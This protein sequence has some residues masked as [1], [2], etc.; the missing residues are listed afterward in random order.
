MYR[1]PAPIVT[2]AASFGD[3]SATAKGWWTD[4]TYNGNSHTVG[5]LELA[6]TATA[7]QYQFSSQ[8]NLVLGGFFPLDPP[9]QFPLYTRRAGRPRRRSRRR[10]EAMVCNLWPYWYSEHQLRRR[11]R[12]QG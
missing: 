3:G 4:N 5:T 1:G 11:E 8:P 7:G 9:G 6:A 10:D 2:S 12:V